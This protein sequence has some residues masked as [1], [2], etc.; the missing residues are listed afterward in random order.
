M[1]E[2]MPEFSF[3]SALVSVQE[4]DRSATFY[5]AVMN[6]REV[7][8]EDQISVLSGGSRPFTLYLRETGRNSSHPGQQALGVRTLSFNVESIP[9]LDRVEENLK[10]HDGFRERLNFDKDLGLEV[11]HGLDPDRLTLMFVAQSVKADIPPDV[12]HRVLVSMYG[13]DL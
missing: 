13:L 3:R 1:V 8:R 5:Q 9:E 12:Y 7:I 2:G 11:V 6:L 4:I 10:A